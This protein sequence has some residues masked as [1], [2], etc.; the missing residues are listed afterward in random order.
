VILPSV[1]IITL[2]FLVS[3]IGFGDA[4]AQNQNITGNV[5]ALVNKG[6]SLWRLGQYQEAIG[7]YDRALI[8]DPN[9]VRALI[10][11]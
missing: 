6:L 1:I 3:L 11:Y 2:L 5:D 8:I 9:S 10:K 4:D 7:Y